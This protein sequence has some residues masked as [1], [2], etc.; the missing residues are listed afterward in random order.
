[1]QG[2]DGLVEVR[3]IAAPNTREAKGHLFDCGL[4]TAEIAE[5]MKG[6]NE[7]REPQPVGQLF[8]NEHD[9]NEERVR[10]TLL[11]LEAAGAEYDILFEGE[12]VTHEALMNSLQQ[13]REIKEQLRREGDLREGPSSF[14]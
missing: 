6:R 1:M 2:E 3:I 7:E 12:P 9:E 10:R 13:W 8:H 5:V 11:S 4:T 14:Q